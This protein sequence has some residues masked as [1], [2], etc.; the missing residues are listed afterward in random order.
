MAE[1]LLPPNDQHSMVAW[2]VR[3]WHE[4]TAYFRAALQGWA[5]TAASA[6]LA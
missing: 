4:L 3:H 2:P 5:D 6:T 1:H